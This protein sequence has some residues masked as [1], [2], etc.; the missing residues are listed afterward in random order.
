VLLLN[1]CVLVNVLVFPAVFALPWLIDVAA[2][3]TT[4]RVRDAHLAVRG[5][6]HIVCA[7]GVVAVWAGVLDAGN[8]MYLVIGVLEV[9]IAAMMLLIAGKTPREDQLGAVVMFLGLWLAIASLGLMWLGGAMFLLL[10]DGLLVF[11]AGLLWLVQGDSTPLVTPQLPR[12]IVL[13]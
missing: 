11:L 1:R 8:P 10:P 2:R 3:P 4:E 12:A 6:G 13:N 7:I 9:A 5:V